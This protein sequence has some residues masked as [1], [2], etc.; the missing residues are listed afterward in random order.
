MNTYM[1]LFFTHS[2]AIKFDK[3]LKNLGVAC[4]L[5]PVPRILSSNC[6]IGGEVKTDEDVLQYID[7]DVE[8]V[9]QKIEN[10]Y[11]LQYAQE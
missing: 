2:G 1:I 6:G 11:T 9:F 7:S 3:K 8:K 10:D 5:M 4:T